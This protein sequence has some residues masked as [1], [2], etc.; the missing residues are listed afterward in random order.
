MF[1]FFV[2]IALPQALSAISLHPTK[3]H[4]A[5]LK[6]VALEKGHSAVLLCTLLLNLRWSKSLNV[7][8]TNLALYM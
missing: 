4:P 2:A 5:E 6:K 7:S 3:Y 1:A 8:S